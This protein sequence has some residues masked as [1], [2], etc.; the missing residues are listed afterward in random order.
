[1]TAPCSPDSTSAAATRSCRRSL[2]PAGD[3][4][5]RRRRRGAR[6][7]RRRPRRVATTRVRDLTERF[8]GCGV[9]DLRVARPTTRRPRSTRA[10]PDVP[11]RARRTPPTAI[12]AYHELQRRAAEP[13]L[14]RD[15]VALARGRASRSTA[16]GS[17]CPGG[18]AA[19]PSTV[20]MTAIP[21]QR[22]R[23]RRDRALRA[24][25]RRRRGPR[26]RRSRPPRSSGSTRCT[27]S[28][29][30]RRSPRSPTAPRSIRPVDVIV[31]PG[32]ALRRR[33]PSARSRA[34]SASTRSP[35]PS[36]VVVVADGSAPGRRS[37]PPTS[38]RRPSTVPAAPRSSSPGTPTSPTRSTPRSTSCV[39]DAP[40]RAEIA[41]TLARRRPRR[42]RRRRRRRRSTSVNAIAPEHLEL[43][44]ADPEALVPLV[45][46]AGAVF[47]GP[48]APAALGD[49]V[50]GRQPRAA[51][52]ARTA[53]FASALRVDTFRKHVHV[54]ARH[55]RRPRRRSRRTS[56][57]SPRPRGSTRTRARSTSGARSPCRGTRRERAGRAARRPARARGLPLAAA[58]RVG[59]A[60]HQREP[61]PAA[62]RVRRRAGSTSCAHAP[63]NRYPDRGARELRDAL[64]AHLGQP[65]ERLFCA[66][67]SNEVLQTLLLT[68]GGPGRR[69]RVFEPTYALHSHIARITGTEVVVGER[70]AD[71]SIDR[72]RGARARRRARARRSCSCAAP[73]TRP[74]PSSPPPPSRRCSTPTRRPRRGRR[75]VRRVR[76]AGARSSSSPTTAAR[77]RAHV[78]EGVVAGRAAARLRGRAAVGGRGAREGRAAVPPR[79]RPRRSRDGSRSSSA[80]RWTTGS[81]RLV[82]ERERLVAR[83]RRHR[84][85]SP[86]SRRARTSCCSRSHG[87]G[88]ALWQRARRP[89]RARARLLA[90][91]APRRTACGSPSARPR[92]TTRSS[93][94]LRES[95]REVAA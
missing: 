94:A 26:G 32:N 23:R 73:T 6:H 28:A 33:W 36:E 63:L 77:R 81:T 95:L 61:V 71:F 50:A 11:R 2:Q 82:A 17:T 67:G 15:G 44:T 30:R 39:A 40:R 45:R 83:A 12:R 46:N 69:A 16:P 84:P 10:E 75:G 35:G 59:A 14:E 79:G 49:Y 24:A 38:S 66:N 72:R 20:L 54:V 70:R 92:R 60:Q 25:R 3:R 41:A 5:R 37:S 7:H 65:P 64:G 62:A 88:H 13:A 29:A 4:R 8:D 89:R 1:M 34:S 53:R 18:R 27:A 87:D 21:A 48:W 31:G 9:D 91:A 55:R 22:R 90:L 51:R 56:T 47:L 74:A 42:A 19:Y 68:Y 43:L 85:A 93:R 86:C 52:P 76:A 78:L 80:T 58:R 57:R